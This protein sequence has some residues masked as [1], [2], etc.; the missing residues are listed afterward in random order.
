MGGGWEGDGRGWEVDKWG[1]EE[2]GRGWDVMGGD[3]RG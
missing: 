1:M 3:G 2:I